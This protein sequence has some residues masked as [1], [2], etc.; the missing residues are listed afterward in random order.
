MGECLVAVRFEFL[1][2]ETPDTLPC[3]HLLQSPCQF[4]NYDSG[5]NFFPQQKV[6]IACVLGD[7]SSKQLLEAKYFAQRV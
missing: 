4:V 6:D 3:H 1:A 7:R 2:S 5:A